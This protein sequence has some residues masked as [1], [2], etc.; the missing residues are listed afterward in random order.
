MAKKSEIIGEYILTINDDNS[1]NVSM[2][3]DNTKKE[4]CKIAEENNIPHDEKLTTHQLGALIL[5]ELG[6]KGENTLT[7][8]E[9]EIEK[10]PGGRINLLKTYVNTKKGLRQISEQVGFEYNKD[11]DTR[12][13]GR[14]L[15]NFIVKR[16]EEVATTPGNFVVNST[17]TVGD[18]NKQFQS[19]YGGYL[20]IY[21]GRSVANDDEKLVDMGAKTGEF[22][23]RA[24]R[25]VGS[26]VEAM[27]ETFELKVKVW[28]ADEWVTVLDGITLSKVRDLP[29]Q[30]TKAVLEAYESYKR[31][32]KE[33][34]D[35][36]KKEVKADEEKIDKE[37]SK[38]PTYEECLKKYPA[39]LTADAYE[40]SEDGKVMSNITEAIKGPLV[41][42]D[43]VEVVDFWS[44]YSNDELTAFILPDSVKE[45][46]GYL[47]GRSCEKLGFVR[48]SPNMVLPK[49]AFCYC[50]LESIL[51]PEGIKTIPTSAFK[52]TKLKEL[53][54]PESVEYILEDAFNGIDLEEI[55]I[56]KNV[57]IIMSGA[58]EACK[59]LKK[60]TIL[61]RDIN[62]FPGAFKNCGQL[63]EG[64]E[65]ELYEKHPVSDKEIGAED[66]VYAEEERRVCGEMIKSKVL[67]YVPDY[68]CGELII[69]EG[70]EK[71]DDRGGNTDL[72]HKERIT[73]LYIPDSMA[74]NIP[75][76][77]PHVKEVRFP[78]SMED[79]QESRRKISIYSDCLV[80]FNFPDGLLE[81]NIAKAPLT[82]LI[83]P[84]GVQEVSIRDMPNLKKL[85]LPSTLEALQISDLPH[86]EDLTI[87]GGVKK[88]D[89]NLEGFGER[90]NNLKNIT[91][92]DTLKTIG[93]RAFYGCE[94][95]TSII[96]PS[97]VTEIA[98]GAFSQCP[99]LTEV[100][101]EGE[102]KIHPNAF[103]D[104]PGY[105]VKTTGLATMEW[106]EDGLPVV[107]INLVANQ[108]DN[109][110]EPSEEW[111]CGGEGVMLVSN[112]RDMD[113]YP[114]DK[115]TYIDA[116]LDGTY[117]KLESFYEE[118][119]EDCENA[120]RKGYVL[121][122]GT[123]E[124]YPAEVWDN[125]VLALN[126]IFNPKHSSVEIRNFEFEEYEGP[127]AIFEFKVYSIH[128]YDYDYGLDEDAE[129]FYEA[130]YRVYKNEDDEWTSEKLD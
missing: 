129:P 66:V 109:Y 10:E 11:W 45:M 6:K 106:D 29:K 17:T 57:K 115:I 39:S 33:E 114:F 74:N 44:S 46:K 83:I 62:I 69:E 94:N 19:T 4:L 23:C 108:V 28:T 56:P 93:E 85:V 13:F 79:V 84:E 37:E 21:N 125:M 130:R 24:N 60:V 34:Q 112:S 103:K 72:G 117:G 42:P 35:T 105:E 70:T 122:Q 67:K 71:V 87:P 40:L 113:R 116:S 88:L 91:L 82:E 127:E 107:K 81:F 68:Y 52:G 92:P 59:N 15:M 101:M 120:L 96:I 7:L 16:D 48:L 80:S 47:Y 27:K 1:V 118:F 32:N 65:K 119:E 100:I 38:F 12:H 104:T 36:T 3:P 2:I 89:G 25:T 95:L 99:N 77:P 8:G 54:L 123:D 126:V 50:P 58:F 97:S 64:T 73:K 49:S 22:S 5:K 20:K 102:P 111:D 110:D 90:C 121:F 41:V 14:N 26:F 18:L 55:I 43:G 128:M 53:T 31:E 63:G 98:D 61:S 76:L 51:I 78:D 30:A 9:Y 86:L 124:D 75:S